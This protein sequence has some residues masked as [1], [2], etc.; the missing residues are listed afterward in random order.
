MLQIG[1]GHH[2]RAR[3][4]I[5]PDLDLPDP[6]P[7]GKRRLDQL[8]RDDRLGLED[9]RP[10]LVELALV[11][12][13]RLARGEL[14]FRQF[15]IAL[16]GDL[17]HPHLRLVTSEVAALGRVVQLDQRVA[18]LDR[19]AG[20]E[21]DL[22]QP[23]ADLGRDRHLM[24]RGQRADR[25]GEMRHRLAAGR[26]RSDLRRRRPVAGEE[27]RD[28]LFAEAVEA[29]NTAKNETEQHPDDNKPAHRLRP[30]PGLS[31]VD[32]VARDGI[33]RRDPGRCQR[34]DV[35]VHELPQTDLPN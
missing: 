16:D 32:H 23:A 19:A 1:Q 8:L 27:F 31:P 20:G 14:L 22:R 35:P 25:G 9:P 5:L 21:K 29:V 2:R 15:S 6:E 34:I 12:V 28:L 26:H 33:G 17:R 13:D 7:P 3:V 24:H 10:R 11:L 30:D 4:Q 18:G